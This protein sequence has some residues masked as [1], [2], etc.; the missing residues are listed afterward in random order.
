MIRSAP[1]KKLNLSKAIPKRP[2]GHTPADDVSVVASRTKL[3]L[4]ELMLRRPEGATTPQLMLA[5]NWQKHSVRG[6]IS[7]ALRKKMNLNVNVE[8]PDDGERIYRI[9]E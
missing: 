3:E 4:L 1:A 6:A 7:G 2:S 8:D 5:L 9:V